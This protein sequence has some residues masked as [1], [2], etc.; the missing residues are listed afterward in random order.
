MFLVQ[1]PN[2]QLLRSPIHCSYIPPPPPPPPP[3]ESLGVGGDVA[4]TCET[5]GYF[6][7]YQ[8]CNG[9]MYITWWSH[10]LIVHGYRC[11]AVGN[12][13]VVRWSTKLTRWCHHYMFVHTGN[14]ICYSYMLYIALFYPSLKECQLFANISPSPNTL[15]M[16]PS[17]CSKGEVFLRTGKLLRLESGLLNSEIWL[18]RW[19]CSKLLDSKTSLTHAALITVNVIIKARTPVCL[20]NDHL[21]FVITTEFLLVTIVH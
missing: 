19:K 1:K 7:L 11:S 4:Y 3:Q 17:H 9:H 18:F 13:I 16:P 8:A 10:V 5:A 20:D 15:L 2:H 14:C 21:V 12:T 6:F